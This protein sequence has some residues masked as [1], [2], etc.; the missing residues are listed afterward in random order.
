VKWLFHAA[1]APLPAEGVK[2]LN[3]RA[4]TADEIARQLPPGGGRA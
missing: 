4:E 3:M 1:G 2:V